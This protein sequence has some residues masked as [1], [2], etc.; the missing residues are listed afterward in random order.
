MSNFNSF[1]NHLG[2]NKNQPPKCIDHKMNIYPN[3]INFC[4]DKHEEDKLVECTNIIS[5]SHDKYKNSTVIVSCK[6]LQSCI[7][8]GLEFLALLLS[9]I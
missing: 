5:T 1:Y 6:K 3:F 9:L 2:I 4:C 7:V 8:H